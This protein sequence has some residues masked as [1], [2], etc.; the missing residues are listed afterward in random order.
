MELSRCLKITHLGGDEALLWPPKPVTQPGDCQH[1]Q[2]EGFWDPAACIWRKSTC[3]RKAGFVIYS[4]ESF[5]N[6]NI[7]QAIIWPSILS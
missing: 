5:F 4:L 3:T 1:L 2:T 7:G 6:A